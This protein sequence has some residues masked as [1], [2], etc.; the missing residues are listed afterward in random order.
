MMA[1][2]AVMVF[3]ILMA[4]SLS[5]VISMPLYATPDRE[6]NCLSCHTSGQIVVNSP[7]VTA[8]E[9]NASSS[10]RIEVSAEG[11][12]GDLTVKWPSTINPLFAFIPSRVTDNGPNDVDPAA[13]KVKASSRSQHPQLQENTRYRFSPQIVP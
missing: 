9:V 10:F 8:L 11:D 5:L 6:D 1:K 7:N 12:A 4:I 3:G 2:K 13:N